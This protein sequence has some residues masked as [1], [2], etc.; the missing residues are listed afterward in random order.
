VFAKA[1]GESGRRKIVDG[2]QRLATIAILFITIRDGLRALGKIA[3]ADNCT[4]KACDA[5][6]F[7]KRLMLT[8][9]SSALATRRRTMLY[10]WQY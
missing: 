1:E 4:K 6:A 2:Q 8:A 5:S 10:W 9:L 7:A 3:R